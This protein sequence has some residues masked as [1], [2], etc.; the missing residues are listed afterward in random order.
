MPQNGLSE[1]AA[2]SLEEISRNLVSARMQ[3]RALGKFPGELPACLSDA[4]SIQS[5]SIS[6]WPDRIAGWKVGMVPPVFQE[7]VGATRL[8]GPIFNR[9]VSVGG[10]RSIPMP[11]FEGGFA[12][13]EAEIVFRVGCDIDPATKLTA[14]WR[15]EDFIEDAMIGIE[16]ASS[17]LRS[18]NDLGPMSI[19]SDFGNNAGLVIGPSIKDWKDGSFTEE[20]VSVELDGKIVGQARPSVIPG[21]PLSSFR[22]LIESCRARGI[23][24]DRG[25]LVSTGAIT[26]VH[27]ASVGSSATANFGRY[28][29][30]RVDLCEAKPSGSFAN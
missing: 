26:G 19:I 22:F 24:V 13:V 21:G 20:T 10:D 23:R 3:A 29:S 17:P 12:A 30:I 27:E 2:S 18:I 4:Y 9:S 6:S 15:P 25:I 8:A 16:I 5:T 1:D 28:G 11:V 14:D 7:L